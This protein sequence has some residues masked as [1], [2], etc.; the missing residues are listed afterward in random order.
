MAGA[1]G[2]THTATCIGVYQLYPSSGRGGR[3]RSAGLVPAGIRHSPRFGFCPMKNALA[4]A[5]SILSVLVPACA[6]SDAE[7]P[8]T[9]PGLTTIDINLD[10]RGGVQVIEEAPYAGRNQGGPFRQMSCSGPGS[11]CRLSYC[12]AAFLIESTTQQDANCYAPTAA[13][14]LYHVRFTAVPRPGYRVLQ[15][16][17]GLLAGSVG[18][19]TIRLTNET[20]ATVDVS[21][22]PGPTTA[23]YRNILTPVFVPVDLPPSPDPPASPP[24]LDLSACPGPATGL[25]DVGTARVAH[26]GELLVLC[27]SIV[28]TKKDGSGSR[29]VLDAAATVFATDGSFVYFDAREQGAHRVRRVPIDG[30]ASE[31]IGPASTS[32]IRWIGVDDDHVYFVGS[33]VD[34]EGLYSAFKDGR[35]YAPPRRSTMFVETKLLAAAVDGTN[36]SFATDDRAGAAM[37]FAM[38]K[39]SDVQTIPNVL[40]AS[41]KPS[42][43]PLRFEGGKLHWGATLIEGGATTELTTGV[44]KDAAFA[45]APATALYVTSDRCLEPVG[46]NASGRDC[47]V[48][49]DGPLVVD[50]G[51]VYWIAGG[52]I[53]RTAR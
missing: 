8:A 44:V 2:F 26:V 3:R 28:R 47:S 22:A 10:A 32:A 53:V 7:L 49:P 11:Y 15:W 52:A 21:W 39:G 27:G 6:D 40:A 20:S 16:D 35:P 38:P 50:D 30:G 34:G 5:C 18:N 17:V 24:R 42:S 37:V 41:V 51:A 31:P 1:G 13:D 36:V 25:L 29:L 48:V 45:P 4:I 12:H 46:A 9:A 23:I 14:G 33:G 19:P 43:A